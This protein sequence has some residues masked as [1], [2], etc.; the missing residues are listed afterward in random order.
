MD[1]I[2]GRF[3]A[4]LA[5][6]SSSTNVAAGGVGSIISHRHGGE[7]IANCSI[8]AN[9]G[10][11]GGGGEGGGGSASSSE[12]TTFGRKGGSSPQ[13]TSGPNLMD[14]LAVARERWLTVR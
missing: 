6:Q 2:I 5:A 9:G 10:G 13:G 4:Q 14:I 12:Q 1:D 3:A 7:G 8:I 11:G